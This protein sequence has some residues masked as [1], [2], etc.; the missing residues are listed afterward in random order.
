MYVPCTVSYGGV[1]INRRRIN[2]IIASIIG[3]R[4]YVL[5]DQCYYLFARTLSRLFRYRCDARGNA[6]TRN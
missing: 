1:I 2:V 3:K 6:A 5:L 4:P